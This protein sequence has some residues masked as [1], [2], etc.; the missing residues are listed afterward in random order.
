LNCVDSEHR[1]SNVVWS[2][3]NLVPIYMV[4]YPKRLAFSAALL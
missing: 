3:S 1:S 2:I 4:S